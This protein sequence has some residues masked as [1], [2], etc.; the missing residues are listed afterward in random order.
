[1]LCDDYLAASTAIKSPTGNLRA[2]EREMVRAQRFVLSPLTV[3]TI[4]DIAEPNAVENTRDYLFTPAESTWIEWHESRVGYA[5][6]N[7]HGLLLIGADQPD[8]RRSISTGD[9]VYV[10][11]MPALPSRGPMG[12]PIVYDLHGDGSLMRP[13]IGTMAVMLKRIGSDLA[14]TDIGAI[15]VWLGAA[16]ALINTP[17]LSERVLHTHDKI[18]RAREKHNKPPI[19]S[20]HEIHIKID[21]GELGHSS[22]APMTEERA[23]HHVR[24]HLRLRLGKVELVRPHWRGNPEKG[25]ILHRHSVVRAEDE[26]GTWQGG[27][28]PMPKIIKEFEN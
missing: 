14:N 21:A 11:D 25:V 1:M 13:Q 4:D 22:G 18:N 23:F 17:R 2:F 27:P 20:W 8:G 15:G 19:L 5:R 3:Q 10:C 6:S 7:R 24:A 16:L 26:P 9:G 28:L 12:V